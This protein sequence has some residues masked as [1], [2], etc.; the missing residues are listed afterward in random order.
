MAT[1]TMPEY[2]EFLVNFW[3]GVNRNYAQQSVS[4]PIF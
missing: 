3:D 2:L 4:V 1:L